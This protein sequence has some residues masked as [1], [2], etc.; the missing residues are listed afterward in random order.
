MQYTLFLIIVNMY[1]NKTNDLW[2]FSEISLEDLRV[3]MKDK[4]LPLLMYDIVL[5]YARGKTCDIGAQLIL[6][7]IYFI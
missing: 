2:L 1:T 3:V 5:C 4:E 7:K 6:E